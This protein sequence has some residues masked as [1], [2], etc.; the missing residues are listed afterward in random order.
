VNGR[1]VKTLP[2]ILGILMTA[3]SA[4]AQDRAP[5]VVS[6]AWLAEHLADK[7][8]VLLHVGAKGEFEKEHIHGAQ[9]IT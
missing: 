5:L 8:L 7:N 3:V 9:S 6:P 2:V 4:S 1:I